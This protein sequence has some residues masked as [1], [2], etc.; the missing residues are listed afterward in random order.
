MVTNDIPKHN[1]THSPNAVVNMP[2]KGNRSKLRKNISAF[3]F[4]AGDFRESTKCRK[5]DLLS[6]GDVCYS[7][8]D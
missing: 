6:F 1:A 2:V 5:I 4:S 3:V 7:V 8:N